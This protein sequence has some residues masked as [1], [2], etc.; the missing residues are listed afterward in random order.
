M[1]TKKEKL[2]ILNAWNEYF[3]HLTLWKDQWLL[4]LNGGLLTGICL[5]RTSDKTKYLPT[6]FMH[7]LLVPFSTISLSYNVKL[8]QH[9]GMPQSLKY[10]DFKETDVLRF[11]EQVNGLDE[12]ITFELFFDHIEKIYNKTYNTTK[13]YLPHLL[14]DIF[15]IGS[16]SGDK[17]FYST[18]LGEAKQML[19][20]YT[21]CFN[22]GDIDEWED[23]I[24]NLLNAEAKGIIESEIKIHDLPDLEDMTMSYKRIDNYLAKI[25]NFIQQAYPAERLKKCI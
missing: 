17:E 21:Q 23:E 2:K 15:T 25:D 11:K 12:P 18:S 22:Y 6:F 24:I 16:Y 14:K 1:A 7:N 3:P 4:Q 8:Q 19:N 9:K 13:P 20:R 5:D 10:A